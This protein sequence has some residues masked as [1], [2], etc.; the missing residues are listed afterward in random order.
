MKIN[1]SAQELLLIIKEKSIKKEE[2]T[3]SSDASFLTIIALLEP[4]ILGQYAKSG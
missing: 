2:V 1:L 4:E 3:I